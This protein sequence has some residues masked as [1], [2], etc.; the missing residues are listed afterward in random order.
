MSIQVYPYFCVYII[1][2]GLKLK[3]VRGLSDGLVLCLYGL[4]QS[5]VVS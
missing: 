5:S 1:A 3:Y 4:E 2:R